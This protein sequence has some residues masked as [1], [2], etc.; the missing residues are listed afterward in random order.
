M[1]GGHPKSSQMSSFL[2]TGVE[3]QPNQV[4]L[5]FRPNSRST[6]A[7]YNTTGLPEKPSFFLGGHADFA[8]RKWCS[9]IKVCLSE[10]LIKENIVRILLQ[11]GY[12]TTALA[13][14]SFD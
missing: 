14:L 9:P 10:L 1:L 13:V 6:L 7:V 12:D 2:F 3:D 4:Q 11:H 8:L 5:S